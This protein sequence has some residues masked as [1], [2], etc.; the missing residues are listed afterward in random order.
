MTSTT[1]LVCGGGYDE[2][3]CAQAADLYDVP[4]VTQRWVVA[5]AQLGR[6]AATAAYDPTA[7]RLFAKMCAA[8]TEVPVADRGRLYAMITYHGGQVERHMT[9]NTT[10]LICGSAEGHAFAKSFTIKREN[11]AI[12]TPDWVLDSL[13][14]SA[15]VDPVRYHPKLLAKAKQVSAAIIQKIH[16]QQHTAPPVAPIQQQQQQVVDA[17]AASATLVPSTELDKQ[18]LSNILGFDFDDAMDVKTSDL[19][20]SAIADH[21]DDMQ[22]LQVPSSLPTQILQTQL[23]APASV[24]TP[25]TATTNQYTRQLSQPTSQ[26]S[27]QLL[28][29]QQP[30]AT[31]GPLQSR[32][33]KQQSGGQLV[34]SNSGSQI[35]ATQAAI[36]QQITAINQQHQLQ[37]QQ[38]KLA[39]AGASGAA[40]GVK[41]TSGVANDLQSGSTTPPEQQQAP[42]R[43]MAGSGKPVQQIMTQVSVVFGLI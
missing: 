25:T 4:S 23:S 27:A 14:A 38:Q 29:P 37:Q 18:T 39:A 1:H 8:I 35:I 21:H 7:N 31:A 9:A 28:A 20:S 34:R 5:C 12:V 3:E 24:N 10:H 13:Q 36:Q 26:L 6:L 43:Q 11:F 41:A 19:A 33:T 42:G 32:Q 40:A 22:V 30:M 17:A 2:N 16:K 15:L